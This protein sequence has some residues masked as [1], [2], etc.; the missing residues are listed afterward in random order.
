MRRPKIEVFIAGTPCC[1]EAL[2]VVANVAGEFCD[3]VVHNLASGAAAASL[4]R[5]RQLRVSKV[6]A[7]AIDGLLLDATDRNPVSA[8]V[9]RSKLARK[10]A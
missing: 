8:V 4:Q 3:I 7:V 9:L 2:R 5:A 10:A 1:C 6:P